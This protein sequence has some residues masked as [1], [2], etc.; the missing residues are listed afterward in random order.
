MK[1]LLLFLIFA[2]LFLTLG[3]SVKHGYFNARQIQCF[4]Q[5]GRCPDYYSDNVSFLY[6]HPL[7]KPFPRVQLYEKFS[8]YPE[9][10]SINFY[11]RL[12]STIIVSIELRQPIGTITS[13][14]LGA[15]AIV[16]DQGVVFNQTNHSLLPSLILSQSEINIGSKVDS[17]QLTAIKHLNYMSSLLGSKITGVLEGVYLTIS[18]PPNTTIIIDINQQSSAWAAP[19]QSIFGRSKIDGKIP[20]KIDL[21]FSSPIVTY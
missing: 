8:S 2:I 19:L 9:I 3:A 11:R 10:R 7:Y 5:F 1:I 18:L 6:K 13:S 16:D 14:V 21:R 12:P 15:Q 17:R 20:R 4:T